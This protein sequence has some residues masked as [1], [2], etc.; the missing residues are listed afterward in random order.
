[1]LTTGSVHEA[2]RLAPAPRWPRLAAHLVDLLAQT[3]ML[4]PIGVVLVLVLPRQ[5]ELLLHTATLVLG[6]LYYVLLWGLAGTSPGKRLFGLRVVGPD[7][8]EPG[9]RRALVRYVVMFL[10][11]LPL[12]LT[13]WPILFRHDRRALHDLA[14]G[15]QVIAAGRGQDKQASS[16][17]GLETV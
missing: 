10:A 3:L 6:T 11:G 7:G 13:W 8:R 12:G 5:G 2:P 4:V 15:T 14:A 9:L 1:M 16:G 17:A